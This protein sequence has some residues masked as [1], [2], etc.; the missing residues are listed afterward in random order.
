MAEAP[1]ICPKCGRRAIEMRTRYGIRASCCDLWSWDR[2]PLVCAATHKA[3]NKAHA[4]FDP[5]WKGKLLN[6]SFSYIALSKE[7]GIDKQ[8]CH[9]ALMSKEMAARVPAAVIAIKAKIEAGE[10]T[11]HKPRRKREKQA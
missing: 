10:Y 1:I 5:I 8:E 9:M 7:L 2:K 11:Y 3:R 6:R 4:A